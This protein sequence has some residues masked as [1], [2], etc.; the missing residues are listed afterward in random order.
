[1]YLSGHPMAE[2]IDAY[3]AIHA[4][5]TGE[6]LDD[7][8][9]Q[10]GRFH[11]GDSVTLLGIV[12][13]VKMKVTKS[14][15]TMAFVT[16]EDM[17]GA[18]EVLVFPKILA[19]YGEWIA[20]GK[21]VR[22]FGRI[23]MRE[24]ED[25]KLLCESVSAPPALNPG[26]VEEKPPKKAARPGL[27][28]KVPSEDSP[29]YDRAKKYLAVFDGATPL[30]VYFQDTKKLLRAPASMRVSINDVLLRELN[31]LLGEKN[32]VFVDEMQR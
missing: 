4:S 18:M 14:N 24:D 2:Y 9:E 8:R 30:Y 21:V 6:I 3:D 10:G 13:A 16:L 5:R 7:A 22:M 11:D 32:V 17:F 26:S 31:K 19:Q 23:S 12:A 29:Q 25:A 1:M 15:S 27:Y 28:L 20:E